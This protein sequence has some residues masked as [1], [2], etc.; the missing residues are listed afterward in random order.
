MGVSGEILELQRR[1][2]PRPRP[3]SIDR[4]RP[5][6]VGERQH[7]EGGDQADEAMS[8]GDGGR[9]PETGATSGPCSNQALIS[10]AVIVY[11]KLSGS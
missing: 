7:E 5:G 9:R 6:R 4:L 10:R 3:E 2:R 11:L 1:R 8:A